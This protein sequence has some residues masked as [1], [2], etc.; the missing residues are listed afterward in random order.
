MGNWFQEAQHY[1][2][3]VRIPTS[4]D[5][6]LIQ[7]IMGFHY[8]TGLNLNMGYLP[9]P[10]NE[11]SKVILIII[12]PFGLFECQVLPQ[13][14]K[15]QITLLFSHF[16]CN[17]PKNYPDDMLHTSGNS[18][19][20][21]IKFLKAIHKILESV[22]KSMQEG[23]LGMQLHWSFLISGLLMMITDH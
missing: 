4:N 7:S 22:Y 17:A 23:A 16:R 12:M 8:V 18:F 1:I 5:G 2:N 9:M 14:V 6:N 11:P 21:N 20:Y 19:N 13:V 3:A 10:F 15:H